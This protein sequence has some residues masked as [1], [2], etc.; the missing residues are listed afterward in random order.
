MTAPRP[1]DMAAGIARRSIAQGHDAPNES[2]AWP[3]LAVFDIDGTLFDPT[4][5]IRPRVRRAVLAVREAGTR[6]M[7]ATGRS[8]WGVLDA[9]R[10]LGLTGP[11]VTMNGAMFSDPF[12]DEVEWARTLTAEVLAEAIEFAREVGTRPTVNL[13][14]G[15]AIESDSDGS[16]PAD[17]GAWMRTPRLHLVRSLTEVADRGPLRFY[18]P[19]GH[20]RHWRAVELAQRMFGGRAAI[21]WGDEQGVEILAP[22]TNKGAGVRIAAESLGYSRDDVMA[23]GDASNDLEMLEWAGRSAAMGNASA[24]VLAA[25]GIVVPSSDEDGVVSAI[26]CF[27]PGL[28]I[29]AETEDEDTAEP[30]A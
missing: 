19:T 23:V 16:I 27:F 25:A 22:G 7:L 21:V 26:E 2:P 14:H 18:V 6:V 8:P 5:A 13:V 10:D 3:R 17:V 9:A 11:H 28:A 20:E 1:G 4:G 12:T 15:Y 24:D 29:D 30:A